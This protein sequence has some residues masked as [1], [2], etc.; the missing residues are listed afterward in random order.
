MIRRKFFSLFA[1]LFGGAAIA[2]PHPKIEWGVMNGRPVP[3]HKIV[4]RLQLGG[5]KEIAWEDMK[6][7][8][9]VIMVAMGANLKMVL[10]AYEIG[11]ITSSQGEP[12]I[13]A[14]HVYGVN[15]GELRIIGE[16]P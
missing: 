1:A 2:N 10:C 9:K 16:K 8:D 13:I 7:G 12:A 3:P 14:S 6:P 15:L 4:F 11:S 5:W